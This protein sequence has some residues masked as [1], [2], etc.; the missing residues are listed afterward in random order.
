MNEYLMVYVSAGAL[1]GLSLSSLLYSLGGRW[2]KGIRRF[3]A[4]FVLALTVNLS[5]F[6]LGVWSFWLLALYPLF[7]IQFI[8]GYSDNDGW[9][10]F[11]RSYI[12]LWSVLTGVYLAW[13]TGSW[14]LLI[15]HVLVS[16]GTIL[17]SMKNPI[18]APAEETLVCA[19]NNLIILFYTFI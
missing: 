3:G 4:S 2:N 11:K 13:L 10:W 15:P 1:V 5:S 8:F 6:F 7:I 18:K 14:W 19:L 12:V 16:S 17:F 9:G